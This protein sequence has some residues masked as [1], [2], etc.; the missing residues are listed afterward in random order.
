M[1]GGAW[2]AAVHGVTKSQTRL[3]DF[4]LTFHFHALEKE[5]ATHSSILAWRIPG[6]WEPGGLP[7]MGSHRVGHDWSNLA[8]AQSISGG[9]GFDSKCNFDLPTVS[10]GLLICSWT[11]DV[12]SKSLQHCAAAAPVP[13]SCRSS[14]YHIAGAS[15]FLDVRY[16]LT[17]APVPTIL[18][19]F[20]FPWAWGI[21]SQSL[22][23]P[24]ETTIYVVRVGC[25]VMSGSLR[26]H[27]LYSS[28]LVCPWNSPGKNI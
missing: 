14:T 7:S 27:G 1:D 23:C 8:A 17:V 16:L 4:T 9:H 5:M 15:L 13:H 18:L 22:Q 10:L 20:I 3:S 26:P 28:R 12:S 24:S 19:G 6:M 25:S 11:W 21:S 2:K